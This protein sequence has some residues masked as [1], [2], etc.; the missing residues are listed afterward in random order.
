MQGQPARPRSAHAWL[1]SGPVTWQQ[2]LTLGSG[3]LAVSVMRS[4][5]L[6]QACT[7]SI[8]GNVMHLTVSCDTGYCTEDIRAGQREQL[9]G[10]TNWF[11]LHL[12]GS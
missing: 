6:T 12:C 5:K 9:S 1:A 7:A 4:G 3:V 2:L 10:L 8:A 11:Q